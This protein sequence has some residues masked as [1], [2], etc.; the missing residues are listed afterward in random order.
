M[1]IS[2]ALIGSKVHIE[3]RTTET[4]SVESF[5]A[6]NKKYKVCIYTYLR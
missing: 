4:C 6:C 1:K 5:A 2:D 3:D